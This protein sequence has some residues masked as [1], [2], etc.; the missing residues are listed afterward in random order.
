[1]FGDIRLHEQPIMSP[2]AS[3]KDMADAEILA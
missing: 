2:G 3:F 1:M